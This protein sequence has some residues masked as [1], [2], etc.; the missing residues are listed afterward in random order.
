MFEMILVVYTTYVS[1]VLVANMDG[2]V[3]K[4]LE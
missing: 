1:D 2:S 3:D 4:T